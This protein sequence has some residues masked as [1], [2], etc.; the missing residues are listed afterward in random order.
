MILSII[1]PI[2]NV[3]AYVERCLRSIADQDI[4]K[5]KYEVICINDGSPDNSRDVVIALQKEFGNIILIDQ[6]NQ[7]V[8]RA[9]N[10]GIL[11]ARGKYL[12]FIDPDD[13]ID[14]NSLGSVFKNAED[15]NVQVFF[16]GFT[17]LNE[18][19]DIRYTV[20]NEEDANCVYDGILAY[21][22]AR[23]KGDIDPDRMWGVLLKRDFI[24]GN[25][26][27]FM[28]GVPYLE[29][30]EL[31]VRILYL[32]KR[33]MFL[34]ES[35]YQRTT[36][37]GS[38]TNSRLSHTERATK[39]FMDSAISLYNFRL[40]HNNDSARRVFL[41][42]PIVKFVI[43]TLN[44]SLTHPLFKRLRPTIKKLRSSYFK[45]V[46]INGCNKEYRFYGKTYNISPYLAAMMLYF[47]PRLDILLFRLFRK[48]IFI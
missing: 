26:L 29:D 24:I 30:G 4:S 21:S 43:L 31:I 2:Y 22:L 45:K 44:S 33:C 1:I 25:N 3:E 6:E 48:R 47:V 18:A 17:F 37:I 27:L 12:L 19:G 41:N 40:D 36:R 34:G 15:K 23:G 9:R 38:A 28:A 13:Y 8:S 20:F 46:D 5:D 35:F 16:L 32:A 11:K 10:N 7:G 42:Q 39:G 14:R